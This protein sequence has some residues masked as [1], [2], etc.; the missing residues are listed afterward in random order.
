MVVLLGMSRVPYPFLCLPFYSSKGGP[1]SHG[2]G[3]R[4]VVDR[5]VVR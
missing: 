3:D 4:V 1:R 2:V 5:G